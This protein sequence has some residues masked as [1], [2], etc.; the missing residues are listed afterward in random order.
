VI[1]DGDG[2]TE[3]SR[4]GLGDNVGVAPRSSRTYPSRSLTK[5]VIGESNVSI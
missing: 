5:G 1:G 4:A 3:R 2:E